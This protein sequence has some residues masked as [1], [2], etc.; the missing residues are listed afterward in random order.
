MG[1]R[2]CVHSELCVGSTFTVSLALPAAFQPG[3]EAQP[4]R[5]TVTDIVY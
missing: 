1:G 4:L 2:L 5:Q 3:E